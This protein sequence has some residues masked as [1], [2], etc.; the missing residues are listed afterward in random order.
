MTSFSIAVPPSWSAPV[1]TAIATWPS[2]IRVSLA[3]A[4]A[5]DDALRV[6]A[7]E[8]LPPVP[9]LP[10]PLPAPAHA[11]V[12]GPAPMHPQRFGAY[13]RRIVGS[14]AEGDEVLRSWEAVE[15]VE[16]SELVATS[17]ASHAARLFV[18]EQAAGFSKYDDVVLATS[19][20][21]ANALQHGGG[22]VAVAT[23]TSGRAFVVE[24]TDRRP[25]RVPT[26]LQS[27]FAS[28]SGRGMAIVD[29]I[30]D[31]W[32]ITILADRKIVWAEFA[33]SQAPAPDVVP[34]GAGRE[35]TT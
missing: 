33:T 20:L 3:G 9:V 35:G 18:R 2:A 11:I 26:V 23:W 30:S 15:V 28:A 4:P 29:A 25:D 24:L 34:N 14:V 6:T 22:P 8:A 5:P 1:R 32:G 13:C 16:R 27:T 31:H 17:R 10:S 19:E 12:V 7:F 21:T